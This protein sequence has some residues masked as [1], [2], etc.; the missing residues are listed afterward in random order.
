ML[1]TG[2]SA[3]QGYRQKDYFIATQGP[4]SHTVEDFWRMVW[5][6]RCHSIVMLTELKEREQV[7]YCV[8][9]NIRDWRGRPFLF[10]HL[11][12]F[13]IC[14]IFSACDENRTNRRRA[15]ADLSP[16]YLSNQEKC[17]QYWPSEGSVTFGDYVVELTG[18]TQ[19][20]TFTLK[21][22]V[23]THRPVRNME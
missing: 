20:E 1:F 7:E 11:I 18:D 10:R 12:S 2:C 3:L 9:G 23:V 19:C 21:D 17:F 22:M 4:L 6:W 5:E 15:Y 14:N 8:G 13:Y 16:R